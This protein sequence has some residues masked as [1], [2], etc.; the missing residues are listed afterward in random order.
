MMQPQL[1]EKIAKATRREYPEGI[2]AHGTDA[3][4]F[5][6]CA[7]ASTGR[8]I[9][10]DMGRLEGYRNFCNKLWNA[11]RFVLMNT[12]ARTVARPPT[13]TSRWRCP[14]AGSSRACSRPSARSSAR[15]PASVSISPHRRSMN[16]PGTT[17]ATGTW[18]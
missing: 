12:R 13:P 4:R 15:S 1:A 11:A 6:L 10:F 16:S 8:D 14:S 9:K 3:L 5:T 7:L 17:T 2:R 18:S